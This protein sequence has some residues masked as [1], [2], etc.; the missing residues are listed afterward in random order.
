MTFK[1]SWSMG[2]GSTRSDDAP[3]E[4][5]PGPSNALSEQTVGWLVEAREAVAEEGSTGYSMSLMLAAIPPLRAAELQ[6]RGYTLPDDDGRTTKRTMTHVW[7]W[8]MAL[9]PE[10]VRLC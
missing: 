4:T 6:V 5:V 9:V 7:S 8:A 1:R 2:F 3:I 10:Q